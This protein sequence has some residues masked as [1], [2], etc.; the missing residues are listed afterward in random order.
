MSLKTIRPIVS[1]LRQTTLRSLATAARPALPDFEDEAGLPELQIPSPGVYPKT[2]SNVLEIKSNLSY[3][4]LAHT[5]AIVR[6]VEAKCG[7]VVNISQSRFADNQRAR[8]IF[9]VTV[10]NP[11]LF[12]KPLI[13]EIPQPDLSTSPR[14]T[15]YGPSLRSVQSALSA[16]SSSASSFG[17]RKRKDASATAEDVVSSTFTATVALGTPLKQRLRPRMKHRERAPAKHDK[18]QAGRW[19][20]EDEAIRNVLGGGFKGFYGGFEELSR[21]VELEQQRRREAGLDMEEKQEEVQAEEVEEVDSVDEGVSEGD[22]LL[23]KA[24]LGKV[25]IPEG[26]ASAASSAATAPSSSTPTSSTTPSPTRTATPSTSTSSSTQTSRPS[27]REPPAPKQP[28]ESKQD[29]LARLI[30]ER[31]S[32]PNNSDLPP[33][34]LNSRSARALIRGKEDVYQSFLEQKAEKSKQKSLRMKE[35]SDRKKQEETARG[36]LG[37]IKHWFGF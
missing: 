15:H 10:L 2:G 14:M 17:I 9:Q 24:L 19:A 32:N 6:A 21:S 29:R 22:L 16:S 13:L 27:P 20:R 37:A 31:Q 23:D 7:R 26:S 35:A 11:V 1:A 3:H 33:L 25:R 5:M 34:N 28:T 18:D 8:P 4:T 30:R 12:D 36:A